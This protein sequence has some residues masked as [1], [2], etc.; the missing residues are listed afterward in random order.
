M[1]I[2]LIRIPETIFHLKL[3]CCIPCGTSLHYGHT[4]R[5]S[6]HSKPFLPSFQYTRN[7]L[8][9]SGGTSRI[10]REY[11]SGDMVA[12]PVTITARWDTG[13]RGL[14]NFRGTRSEQLPAISLMPLQGEPRNI[15]GVQAE[16]STGGQP[17]LMGLILRCMVLITGIF[18][19]IH[20]G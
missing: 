17:L 12:R 5:K 7:W 2:F 1:L 3:I 15:G 13:A 6:R 20:Q 14:G 18:I 16:P 10:I 9:S 11:S 8:R 19:L 4:P